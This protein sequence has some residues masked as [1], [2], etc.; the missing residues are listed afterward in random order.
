MEATPP[1]QKLPEIRNKTYGTR[2]L[3]SERTSRLGADVVETWEIDTV[4]SSARPSRDGFSSCSAARVRSRASAALCDGY[5]KD[6]DALSSQGLEGHA[7]QFRGL[8]RHCS[9]RCAEQGVSR[10]RRSVSRHC[11]MRR[12]EGCLVAGGEVARCAYQR[13]LSAAEAI[14]GGRSDPAVECRRWVRVSVVAT[15]R[16]WLSGGRTAGVVKGYQTPA[17]GA[18][19]TAS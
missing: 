4:R 18:R 3:V 8:P 11:A 2:A 1:V 10:A 12:L 9:L 13:R 7:R 16:P 19:C 17:L 15:S 14:D 5:V 6:L